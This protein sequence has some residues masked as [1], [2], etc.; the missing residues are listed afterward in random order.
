MA[1]L[2]ADAR[3]SCSH[4]LVLLLVLLVHLVLLLLHSSS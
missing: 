1:P 3:A 2:Y 4:V